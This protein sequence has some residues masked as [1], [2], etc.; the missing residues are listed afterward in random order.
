MNCLLLYIFKKMKKSQKADQEINLNTISKV[1]MKDISAYLWSDLEEVLV[2]VPIDYK[3]DEKKRSRGGTLILTYGAVY[4]FR[5]QLFSELPPKYTLS[6]LDALKVEAYENSSLFIMT[7]SDKEF[8]IKTKYAVQIVEA[9]AKVV[10][11]CAY[12]LLTLLIL[13]RFTIKKNITKMVKL[14]T[15]IKAKKTKK[16]KKQIN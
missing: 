9:M 16:Q 7:F 10:A 4:I 2:S 6:L 8:I 3:T 15:Q 11:E 12:G 14:K 5:N 1:R 13:P